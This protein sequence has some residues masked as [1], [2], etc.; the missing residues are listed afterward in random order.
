MSNDVVGK[1]IVVQIDLRK[2]PVFDEYQD[3]Y[4]NE[5]DSL[6]DFELDCVFKA[7]QEIYPY[8]SMAMISFND[9]YLAIINLPS[10]L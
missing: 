5:F 6:E 10:L 9:P 2:P 8:H 3:E 4:N 1:P 7:H